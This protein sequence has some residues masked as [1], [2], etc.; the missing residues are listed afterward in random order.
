MAVA[1]AAIF[2]TSTG[3]IAAGVIDATKPVVGTIVVCY[4]T[5]KCAYTVLKSGLVDAHSPLQGDSDHPFSAT[6]KT[7]PTVDAPAF[8]IRNIGDAP[9]TSAK[10][11]IL[12]NATFSVPGDVYVIGTIAP[13]KTVII[14]PGLSNDGRK[15]KSTQF[16]F[17]S[18]SALD[19]SDSS[20]NADAITFRF[21]GIV[22]GHN[23]SSGNIVAGATAGEANDKTVAHLNFLGGPGNADG[24]CNDCFGPKEIGKI[25]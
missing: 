4:F 18:G 19:T 3:A 9:I 5:D 24:P 17:H 1:L 25:K 15:H 23:V 7:Y 2:G 21:T 20:P 12:A 11:T 14:I 8:Q 22:S 10:F 16:F 6:S 13:R